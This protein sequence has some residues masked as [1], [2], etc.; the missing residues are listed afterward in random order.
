MN[1]YQFPIEAGHIMMFARAIGETNPAYFEASRFG[2]ILAPPTFVQ[3]GAQYN[4]NYALRPRPGQ[5]W[6]GTG[7]TSTTTP[8]SGSV[9]QRRSGGS[10]RRGGLH[11]E[12]HFEYHQP[13]LAGDTLFV[14]TRRGDE[15]EKEG[16]RGGSL[17][18]A[19]SIT[20]YRDANGALIV[21]ARG[22]S[23]TTGE[24]MAKTEGT[25]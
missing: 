20:E 9:Q 7:A 2:R 21:T 13:V 11:A 10:R 24:R 1:D 12:Q 23:V 4:P 22:V 6:F 17:H 15:W 16:R 18:F 14:A 25:Q 5:P 3:A 19:E 8:R